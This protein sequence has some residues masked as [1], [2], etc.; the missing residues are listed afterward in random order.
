MAR[1]LVW[2][3]KGKREAWKTL[4]WTQSD[5]QWMIGVSARL[6]RFMLRGA[7]GKSSLCVSLF[8]F[9]SKQDRVF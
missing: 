9:S 6:S 7:A 4:D 8:F 5:D 2:R 1:A 3:G